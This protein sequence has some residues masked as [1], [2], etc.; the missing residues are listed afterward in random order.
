MDNTIYTIGHS[1]H[2]PEKFVQLL[3][4]SKIQVLVDVRS[5]PGSM[6]ATYANPHDLQKI[7]GAK[8][9]QYACAGNVLGG[10]PSDTDCYNSETGKADYK[11]IQN[12][13]T[14]QRALHQLLEGI[15]TYRTCIMCSEEN[16]SKC[17]RNLLVGEAL[18][19]EGVSV[20][21]IRGTGQ[22]QTDEELLNE[23]AGVASN[24]MRLSL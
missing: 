23:D 5:N 3:T 12:K 16:P 2:T 11:K 8:N 14:F 24:Q 7:L 6:W 19:Q 4:D 21:H 9:I 18:R 1:N 13:A 22:I 17:H 10:R 20:L 15:S